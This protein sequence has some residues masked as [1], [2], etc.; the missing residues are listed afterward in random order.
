MYEKVKSKGSLGSRC[1]LGMTDRVRAIGY[2][3]KSKGSF[4]LLRILEVA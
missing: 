4:A 1:S 2:N 3:H